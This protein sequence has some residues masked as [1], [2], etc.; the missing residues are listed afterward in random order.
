MLVWLPEP[1]SKKSC[2]V[3][4]TWLYCCLTVIASPW[5]GDSALPNVGEIVICN[6]KFGAVP[7]C[8]SIVAIL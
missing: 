5:F 8:D 2:P 1:M 7:D 3:R 4:R 6:V